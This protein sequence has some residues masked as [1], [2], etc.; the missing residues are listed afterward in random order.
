MMASI[1]PT[2]TIG[3]NRY[4][5]YCIPLT[6]AHRPAARRILAGE[7]HEP[8]TILFMINN[9]ENMDIIHAGAYFGDFLPALSW[10]LH[11]TAILWAFEPNPEN[12]QACSETVALNALK[13][14]R[15][16]NAGLGDRKIPHLMR[17]RDQEGRSLGGGSRLL[18]YGETHEAESIAV[19]H[20]VRL[21]D[22]IAPERPVGILQLDIEGSEQR[23]LIGAMHLIRRW[24]PALIL[25]G[26]LSPVW[27]EAYLAPLG[28]EE[29]GK[30]HGNHLFLPA[31]NSHR[32]HF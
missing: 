1:R 14:V 20:I 30:I 4:G 3:S 17:I 24:L 5:R 2:R 15:L 22:I 9:H 29:K 10:H 19:V 7:I 13:N 32:A 26:K 8:E 28:Y 11:P 16:M 25:E 31:A 21:D 12:F 23:A 6:S 27:F 18:E